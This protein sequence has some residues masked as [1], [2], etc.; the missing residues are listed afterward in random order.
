MQA[1]AQGD[2]EARH[3]AGQVDVGEP[4]VGLR[5]FAIGDDAAILDL[6]DQLLHRR[7]VEAHHRETIEGQVFDKG[8]EGLLDGVEGLEMIEM[9]GVDIG[10]DRDV[11]RQLEEGAVAF[12]GLHHH[13]FACAQPRVGAIGV[14]DAA[15]DDGR[16]EAARV[17]QGC[18]ERGRRRLAVGSGDGD[19]LL[20]PHQFGEHFG[21]AHHRQAFFAGGGEFRVV[22]LDR[23]RDHHHRGVAEVAGVMADET[24]ARPCRAGA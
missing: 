12:V 5:V 10:D 23:G 17:E 13:P 14:D 6:A 9:L 7:M 4:D 19:A 11:G 18:N 16:I 3:A 20:E 8:A 2:I 15:V 22:A 1:V 24:P 21:A